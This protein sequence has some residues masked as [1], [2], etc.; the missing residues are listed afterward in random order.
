MRLTRLALAAASVLLASNAQAG[1]LLDLYQRAVTND[2][3]L[4]AASFQRDAALQAKPAA[5]SAFLPQIGAQA[6]YVM[7][8]SSSTYSTSRFGSPMPVTIT[9]DQGSDDINLALSATQALFNW[10]ALK[11]LKQADNQIALAETA[12]RGAQQQLLL[13]VTQAYFNVLAARDFV[14][15]A[16]A[17]NQAVARQLDQSQ[18]RFQVGLSA[19]TDVQEAQARFDLTEAQKIDAALQLSSAER[20]LA[21]ITGSVSNT[22]QPVAPSFP[23]GGPDPQDPSTW[24][25]AAKSNNLQLLASRLTAAIAEDD[26]KIARAKHL[27]TVSLEGGYRRSDGDFESNGVSSPTKSDG[28]EIGLIARI[29][30]YNGGV[31]ESGVKSA[32][33]TYEQRVREFESTSRLVERQTGDAYQNVM[34]G[35]SRVK[36]FEAA[37]KSA[38]TALEASQV[39]LQVGARTSIDVLNAQREVSNAERNYASARYNYLISIISLKLSAGRLNEADLAEIDRLLAQ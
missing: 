5:F 3:T 39:G 37:V 16:G 33:A 38:K 31:I 23:L 30:I 11:R 12:Y 13:R 7:Q 34:A 25:E 15:F 20:A 22:V 2:K 24:V 21:E 8:D 1:A 35:I 26:I 4:Q 36:A 19:I 17:E 29:P 18:Q 28:T 10:E 14:T 9:Q 6:S 32:V 27:P